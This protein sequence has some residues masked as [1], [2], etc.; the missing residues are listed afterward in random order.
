[1]SLRVRNR[2]QILQ[3]STGARFHRLCPLHAVARPLRLL[4]ENGHYHVTS[5]TWDRSALF[6]DDEHR[7]EFLDRLS[8]TVERC[9]WR[10]LAYCL[11]DNHFHLLVLTPLANLPRGMQQLN[12]GYAQWFNRQ[13]A[14]RGP[15][16]EDRYHGALIQREPHLLEVFRY[17]ALNPVRAGLCRS[18]HRYVWSSHAAIAGHAPVPDFLAANHV[19]ELFS[20]T[21]GGDG[22]ASYRE[23]VAAAVDPAPFEPPI[24]GDDEFVREAMQHVTRD[25]EIPRRDWTAGR[26]SLREMLGASASGAQLSFAYRNYGYTMASIAEHLRCHVSTVSRRIAAFERGDAGLQDLTP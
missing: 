19:H 14:R 9:D 21:I 3:S 23:F 15:V 2:G 1:M 24:H 5:R 17:I 4:V 10:C 20:S 12:S 26:P 25:P 8:L 22:R 6:R 11:M 18:P 13:R 16:L 7:L